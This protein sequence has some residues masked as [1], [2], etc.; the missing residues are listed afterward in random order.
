[1]PKQKGSNG[2]KVMGGHAVN[3]YLLFFLFI[4]GKTQEE[5]FRRVEELKAELTSLK[6]STREDKKSHTE[7]TQQ[8]TD[9]SEE[10]TKEKVSSPPFFFFLQIIYTTRLPC[11][12]MS[13]TVS[14]TIILFVVFSKRSICSVKWDLKTHYL[15]I[16]CFTRLKNK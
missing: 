12:R 11:R 1:M 16:E 7:L 10:L 2:E 6:E 4:S 13:L 9:L 14:K 3:V 15:D 5:G 8:V